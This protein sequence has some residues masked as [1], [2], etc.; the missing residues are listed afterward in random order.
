MKASDLVIELHAQVVAGAGNL[1][2][3]VTGGYA[4]DLLSCVMAAAQPGNVWI[5]LQAH[6]NVIAIAVLLDLSAVVITEGVHPDAEV[7]ARAEEKGVPVLLCP[8]GTFSAVAQL[9]QAGIGGVR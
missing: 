5:T 1:D 7:L 8:Q 2:R 6:M 9:A 4:S 3:E